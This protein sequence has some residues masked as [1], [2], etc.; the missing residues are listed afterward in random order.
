VVRGQIVQL[1]PALFELL[2]QQWKE[3]LGLPAWMF[4]GGAAPNPEEV[5]TILG[6]YESVAKDPNFATLAARP[7]FQS[8]LS[9]LKHYN[10]TL[11]PTRQSLQ[12]PPPPPG[13]NQLVLP[14]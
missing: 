9:L 11:A 13:G 6:R 4:L 12:L 5:K 10:E 8:V 1:A 2:D 7:E 3:Y 14:N